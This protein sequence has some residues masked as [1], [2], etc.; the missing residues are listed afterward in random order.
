M[1]SRKLLDL[2]MEVGRFTDPAEAGQFRN[3]SL[4]QL[5]KA[6]LDDQLRASLC[7]LRRAAEEKCEP[8]RAFR[9]KVPAH[10]EWTSPWE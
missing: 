6:V 9:N 8:V 10:F 5:E 2:V 4:E 3:L 1:S 7:A